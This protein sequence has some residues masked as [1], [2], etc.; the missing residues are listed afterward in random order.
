VEQRWLPQKGN[1]LSR[2]VPFCDLAGES[3]SNAPHRT[4]PHRTHGRA[5]T[6]GL[7][8]LA[9]F[10]ESIQFAATG[11]ERDG[12]SQRNSQRRCRHS[13]RSIASDSQ[14]ATRHHAGRQALDMCADF[15]WLGQ[16]NLIAKFVETFK[17]A[18]QLTNAIG[19]SDHK[20]MQGNRAHQWLML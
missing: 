15:F 18:A 8:G 3:N 13:Q 9:Q 4:A 12:L 7:P 1:A 2:R 16:P 6:A 17:D 20:G 19:A 11:N 5:R 14:L 10:Q